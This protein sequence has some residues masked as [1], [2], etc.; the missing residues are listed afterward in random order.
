[1]E[2]KDQLQTVLKERDYHA[3]Q[4]GELHQLLG[5]AKS[6]NADLEKRRQLPISEPVTN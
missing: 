5:D 2:M 6:K 1:M 4:N 3:N